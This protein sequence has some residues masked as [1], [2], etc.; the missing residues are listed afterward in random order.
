MAPHSG[1]AYVTIF[2]RGWKKLW[3]ITLDKITV[4]G[5]LSDSLWWESRNSTTQQG[6]INFLRNPKSLITR[7]LLIVH[8]LK[9][10]WSDI[11]YGTWNQRH[12]GKQ[13]LLILICIYSCRSEGTVIPLRPTWLFQF[14]YYKHSPSKEAIFKFT[15]LR[16]FNFTAY[17]KYQG[18]LLLW[19]F[20]VKQYACQAGM[21]Q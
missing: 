14:H 12:D 17:T 6:E 15:R 7:C 1:S 10:P 13:T 9:L 2:D 18:L 8:T 20:I 16:S 5:R 3:S 11:S 19:I 21:S 4:E